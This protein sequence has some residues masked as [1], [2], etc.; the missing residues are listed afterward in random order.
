LPPI[1]EF[2]SVN[3]VDIAALRDMMHPAVSRGLGFELRNRYTSVIDRPFDSISIDNLF[4]TELLK[5]SLDFVKVPAS[6]WVGPETAAHC[7]RGKYRLPFSK[8]MLS[9]W[10]KAVR[11]LVYDD[12]FIAFLEGLT[13]INGLIPM[14]IDEEQMQWAGS[15]IIRVESGG[16][17]YVHN[18][19]NMWNGL[20]RRVNVLLYLN[21]DWQASWGGHLELWGENNTRYDHRILPIFNRV[22]IFSVTDDAYHGHPLPLMTPDGVYRYGLQI[23]YYTRERGATVSSR[24]GVK[25]KYSHA[26]GAI[27]Q[28]PCND[29]AIDVHVRDLCSAVN[30]SSMNTLCECSSR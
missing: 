18:D 19:F 1:D 23:V 13:G 16:L 7:C 25:R 15:N 28:P 14:H 3:T 24:P 27:F 29:G 5:K 21:E 22:T 30:A 4:R 8:W 20:Y 11:A 2:Q 9:K 12:I 6:E 10:S 26:H 17:L